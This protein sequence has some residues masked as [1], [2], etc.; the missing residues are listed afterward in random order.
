M[1]LT[2]RLHIQAL[3]SL[4]QSRNNMRK[5]FAAYGDWTTNTQIDTMFDQLEEELL[6]YGECQLLLAEQCSPHSN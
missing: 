6:S 1:D 5:L 3:E 4:R 2:A